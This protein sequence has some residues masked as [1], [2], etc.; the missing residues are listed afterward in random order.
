MLKT[1]LLRGTVMEFIWISEDNAETF[2]KFI[3]EDMTG[4]IGR[5]Y[6]RSIGVMDEGGVPKGVIVYEIIDSENE[7]DTKSRIHLLAGEGDEIKDS[8]L[9]KY[10]GEASEEEVV[11]SFYETRDEQMSR[12]LGTKGFSAR[13]EESRDLI[14]SV[15]EI[16]KVVHT[17]KKKIPP[18]IVSLSEISV[19]QFRQFVKNCIYQG[20]KGVLEDLA[21]LPKSRFEQNVTACLV[22]DN[23]MQGS[24]L[25]RKAPSGILYTELYVAFGPDYKHNLIYLMAYSAQK[26]VELYPEDTHVVIRRHNE[27]VRT[28]TDRLFAGVRG[29][30]VYCGER[31]ER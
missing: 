24:L 7:E 10:S 21:F 30:Q 12:D 19:P 13:T 23:Q 11:E 1:I 22:T 16:K 26:I 27:Y 17:L 20:R 5:C 15:E 18:Y 8:I 4:E 2:R 6:F 28:L 9:D 3:D 29:E 31:R 25:I 14:V